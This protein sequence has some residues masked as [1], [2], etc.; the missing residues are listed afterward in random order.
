MQPKET[1]ALKLC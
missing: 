1:N